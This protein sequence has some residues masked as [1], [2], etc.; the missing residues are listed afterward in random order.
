MAE[1]GSEP[2]ETHFVAY[3]REPL[4][5][6]SDAERLQALADGYYGLNRACATNLLIGIPET[7]LLFSGVYGPN[8]ANLVVAILVG[9]LGSGLLVYRPMERIGR[10]A[11]WSPAIA[12]VAALLI[13]LN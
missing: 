11:G 10:G 3:P 5:P 8:D 6:Y 13:A 9:T 7:I 12:I 2:P 1:P 4:D